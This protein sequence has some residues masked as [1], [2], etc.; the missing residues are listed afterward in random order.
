MRPRSRRVLVHQKIA[1]LSTIFPRLSH[2]KISGP[3]INSPSTMLRPTQILQPI[4]RRRRDPSGRREIMWWIGSQRHGTGSYQ[5]A[6]RCP[7]ARLFPLTTRRSHSRIFSIPLDHLFS[8]STKPLFCESAFYCLGR[9]RWN[10]RV[11]L[12]RGRLWSRLE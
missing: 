1:I 4:R 10:K 2:W 11:T 8:Q 12:V 6:R 3:A 5:P 7:Q 9:H